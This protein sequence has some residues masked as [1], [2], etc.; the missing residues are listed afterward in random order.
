MNGLPSSP[1]TSST[2]SGR[3]TIVLVF[4][5]CAL[6]IVAAFYLYF[7]NK[8]DVTNNYGTILDPQIPVSATV[9]KNIN[10]DDFSMQSLK[11]KWVLIQVMSSQCDQVC[12]NALFFQRQARASKGKDQSRIERVVFV[13]DN[14]PLETQLLR[15]FPNVHFVRAGE[16]DLANWLPLS[17]GIVGTKGVEAV[18][19]IR[20]HV[21]MADPLGHVMMRFPPNAQLEFDKFRKDISRLLWAS[22]IG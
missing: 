17:Q 11:G 20:D 5:T 8:P 2:R 7:V 13:T 16:A 9:F 10:G 15:A 14:G 21:F 19:S 6:P 12:Q 22:N 1:N 4:L 3:R 18:G